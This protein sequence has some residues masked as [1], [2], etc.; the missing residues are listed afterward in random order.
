MN[1][2]PI[3]NKSEMLQIINDCDVC[4]IGL[5]DE[6]TPYVLPFNFALDGETLYLHSAPEGRKMNVLRKNNLVCISFSTGHKMYFQNEN[7]ACSWGMLFKS[8][9]TWGKVEFVEDLKDKEKCLN[10][11]MKKYAGKEDFSYSLPSLKNV[12]VMKIP[13]EKMTGKKRGY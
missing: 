9:I 4:Y 8:V 12:N 10:L 11:F 1:S 6:D 7:V 13:I 2:T 3:L 5:V